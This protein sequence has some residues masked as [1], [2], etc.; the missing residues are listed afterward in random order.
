MRNR[1]PGQAG[2]SQET[3]PQLSAVSDA[4]LAPEWSELAL[5]RRRGIV[6]R[7][8]AL[9]RRAFLLS[10]LLALTL[11]F[12]FTESAYGSHAALNNS[13]SAGSE[14]IVFLASLPVWLLILKL[15]GLY[16]RDDERTA[17]S[18]ADDIVPVFN[19][20]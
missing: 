9:V 14:Y 8:A 10:D 3:S 5:R 19:A 11:A 7:R 16:R 13:L 17:H 12:V 18:G 1:R 4:R 2:V 6:G 20:I 15:Y